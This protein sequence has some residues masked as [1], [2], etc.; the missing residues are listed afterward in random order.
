MHSHS[1]CKSLLVAT[2]I[3]CYL[4]SVASQTVLETSLYID[5]SNN[6]SNDNG[7]C[8]SSN[9]CETVDYAISLLDNFVLPDGVPYSSQVTIDISENTYSWRETINVSSNDNESVSNW[10]ISGASSTSSVLLWDD[11]VSIN[12]DITRY[13]VQGSSSSDSNR[14]YNV[15]FYNLAISN[16]NNKSINTSYGSG[17]FFYSNPVNGIQNLILNNVLFNNLTR[18]SIFI[19]TDGSCARTDSERNSVY[20]NDVV[21]QDCTFGKNVYYNSDC[22]GGLYMY[23]TV[24]N[25]TVFNGGS[26]GFDLY[27]P[28]LGIIIENVQFINVYSTGRFLY[29]Y[30][31]TDRTLK[32]SNIV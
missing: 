21:F 17:M 29:P 28:L 8:T 11:G 2:L 30:Q 12:T 23:N 9:P 19:F 15:T 10:Y 7:Y 18:S 6:D 5:R 22:G 20:F 31:S 13:G 14:N 32:L 26:V 16:V 24:F 3:S 27:Q 1:T 25:N 4:V